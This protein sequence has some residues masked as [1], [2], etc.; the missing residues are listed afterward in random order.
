[1]SQKYSIGSLLEAKAYWENN[2]LHD[3]LK[4]VTEALLKQSDNSVLLLIFIILLHFG[5]I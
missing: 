5:M 4:E 1:M 2:I 3:R